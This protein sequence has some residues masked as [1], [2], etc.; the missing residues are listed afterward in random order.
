MWL[1]VGSWKSSYK[2]EPSAW[3]LWVLPRTDWIQCCQIIL[4]KIREIRPKKRP[5]KREKI[6][7][8]AKMRKKI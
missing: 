2:C 1:A 8:I 7:C 5:N 4:V 6:L 3:I